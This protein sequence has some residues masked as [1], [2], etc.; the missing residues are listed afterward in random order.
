MRAHNQALN[1][2]LTISLLLNSTQ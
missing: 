2:I 1:S